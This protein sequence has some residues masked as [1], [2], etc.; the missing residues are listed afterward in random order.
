MVFILGG[1]SKDEVVRRPS[2]CSAGGAEA[3]VGEELFL[4]SL[5]RRGSFPNAKL[6]KLTSYIQEGHCLMLSCY[7]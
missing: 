4:A 7:S 2:V 3:G 6:Y 5:K 1:R